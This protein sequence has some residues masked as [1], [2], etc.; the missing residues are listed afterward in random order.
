MDGKKRLINGIK[1]TV[2]GATT[3]ERQETVNCC[4]K[5]VSMSVLMGI[6]TAVLIV[7]ILSSVTGA[8]TAAVCYNNN[9][10]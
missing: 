7:I 1:L 2:G 10:S 6:I 8:V 5:A 3:C 9:N 4:T